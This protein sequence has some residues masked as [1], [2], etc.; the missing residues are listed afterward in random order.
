MNLRYVCF[1]LFYLVKSYCR[2]NVWLSIPK[3]RCLLTDLVSFRSYLSFREWWTS[4]GKEW[5]KLP[6]LSSQI[7]RWYLCTKAA[8][9]AGRLGL[10]RQPFWFI[11]SLSCGIF[12][13]EKQFWCTTFLSPRIFGNLNEIQ[14]FDLCFLTYLSCMNCQ[15]RLYSV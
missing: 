10:T 7:S 11:W 2:P 14:D 1:F 8:R 15:C 4:F 9:L 12:F 5:I 3:N 6:S 13:P